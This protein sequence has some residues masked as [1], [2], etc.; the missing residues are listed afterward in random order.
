MT[1]TKP[2]KSVRIM[3]DIIELLSQ[4]DGTT[5]SEVEETLD[6][7]KST[8]HDYLRTLTEEGY[9]VQKKGQYHLSYQLLYLGGRLRRQNLLYP[10]VR[11]ELR[12]LARETGEHV[13]VLVEERGYGVVIH[14]E[15]G[16]R[17]EGT[18]FPVGTRSHL[19]CSAPGK[20]ILA[21][22]PKER[23]RE[24]LSG[25]SLPNMTENSITDPDKLNKQLEMIKDKGYATD[26]E[27]VLQGMRGLGTAI[28]HPEGDEFLAAISLYGPAESNVVN[29]RCEALLETAN[30]IEVNLTYE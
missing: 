5:L 15:V 25:E 7:P 30:V 17:M 6:M 16:Q 8:V 24:L 1:K 21:N 2:I 23:Q 27:E 11:P 4:H 20:A 29:K 12:D 19:H 9:A 28:A 13:S 18:V 26:Y 10:D 14:T 22:L 3:F